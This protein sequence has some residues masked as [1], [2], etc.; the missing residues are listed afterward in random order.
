MKVYDIDFCVC[1]TERKKKVNGLTSIFLI[2]TMNVYKKSK[3]KVHYKN[4]FYPIPSHPISGLFYSLYVM[5]ITIPTNH[6]M[7][8][9]IKIAKLILFK[10]NSEH[11]LIKRKEVESSI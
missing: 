5:F 10:V 9:M 2:L 3:F 8:F 1:F 7:Y 6:V 4:S 11:L